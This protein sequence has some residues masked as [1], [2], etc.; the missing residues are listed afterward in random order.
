MLSKTVPRLSRAS[1]GLRVASLR[2]LVCTIAFGA[3]MLTGTPLRV[4]ASS[5]LPLDINQLTSGA[6]DIVHARCTGNSV[7]RDATV[8]V[9]TLTTFVVFDR[10]K[11]TAGATF[12]IRQA[13][14][15]ID[16]VKIDYHVP[17]FKVGEEYV[18]FMPGTSRLG[19]AS[20]IGLAQGVFG[21]NGTAAAPSGKEV[22]NGRDFAALL[23]GTAASAVPS[24]IAKR[25]T[26]PA[27]N[28]ARMDLADFM[29]LLHAK[30]GSR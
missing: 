6:Q 11:G 2:V 1:S 9:V 21:V 20:P 13:G 7:Q 14:G 4:E 8:G 15:E 27:R 5:T 26:M 30:V 16:G 28:R 10:V 18:L 22:G 17:K 23:D 3:L 25:L 19:L 12:T 29:T 24:G